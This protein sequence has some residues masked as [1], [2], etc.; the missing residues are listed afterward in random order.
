MYRRIVRAKVR[1]MFDRINAG[2][3]MAMVDGLAPA[4]EYHFHGQHALG[5]KR[6]SRAGMIRWWERVLELLPGARFEVQ[7]V[8][9]NG[10]PWRTRIAVHASISGAL[11][12]GAHYENTVFQFMTLSWGKVV[13]VETVEDL[14][15]LESAL[16]DVAAAGNPA[17]LAAP[18]MD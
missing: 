3:F 16:A 18:I 14:Q 4:F 6:T 17:A 7:D 1:A 15:K 2:D 13:S 9:V 5:G 8:L 10:C 11:P 12:S